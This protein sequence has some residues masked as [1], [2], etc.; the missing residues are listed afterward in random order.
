MT[1]TTGYIN[2]PPGTEFERR[3]VK[4][5]LVYSGLNS[6]DAKVAAGVTMSPKMPADYEFETKGPAIIAGL[7]VCIAAI[8][9]ITGLRLALR[10]FHPRLK[11][12]LDDTLMVPG[13]IMAAAYPAVQIVMVVHGGA[14]KHIYDVKYTEYYIYKW[15]G[16]ASSRVWK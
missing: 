15:V 14:G 6:S 10:A 3:I 13:L 11:W 4:G 2:T 5:M 7:S 12:G 1:H 9:G 16:C 8:V